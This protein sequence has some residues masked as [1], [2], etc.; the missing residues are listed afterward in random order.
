[1]Q[2]LAWIIVFLLVLYCLKLKDDIVRLNR[3]VLIK[4]AKIVNYKLGKGDMTLGQE[5]EQS[6]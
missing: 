3:I 4:E 2:I 1:M 5:N 6:N